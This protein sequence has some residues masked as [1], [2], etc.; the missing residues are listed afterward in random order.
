[1]A[2][3]TFYK[4]FCDLVFDEYFCR[5]EIIDW[6]DEEEMFCPIRIWQIIGGRFY[7]IVF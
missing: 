2:I 3:A 1:M 6:L 4:E 7:K 5:D